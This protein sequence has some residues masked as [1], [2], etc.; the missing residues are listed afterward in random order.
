MGVDHS[1]FHEFIVVTVIFGGLRVVIQLALWTLFWVFTGL[2]VL[3]ADTLV[4]RDG[5]NNVQKVNWL[6]LPVVICLSQ[7]LSHACI[8]SRP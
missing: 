7:R 8:R 5:C 2:S 4:Y 6:I 3:V 1:E